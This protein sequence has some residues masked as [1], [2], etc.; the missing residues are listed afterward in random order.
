M[1]REEQEHL[2]SHCPKYDDIR[3][4]YDDIDDDLDDDSNLVPFFR[5]VLRRRDKLLEEKEEENTINNT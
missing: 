3:S 4:K 5:E 1:E 2:R